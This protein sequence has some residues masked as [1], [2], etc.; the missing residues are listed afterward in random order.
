MGKTGM[1]RQVL[2]TI[3]IVAVGLYL[4]D[5]CAGSGR[6]GKSR[7]KDS[8]NDSDIQETIGGLITVGDLK[9]REGDML[10]I[11]STIRAPIPDDMDPTTEYRVT[12]D[13]YV[14]CDSE[15]S[16]GSAEISDEDYM[17]IYAFCVNAAKTGEFSKYSEDYLDGNTYKLTYYDPDGK[18]YVIYDGYCYDNDSLQ[19]IIILVEGYS[20]D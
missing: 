20:Y 19:D 5:G 17:E 9:R 18:E 10:V 13:G 8:D 1:I 15:Y 12:Y 11:E 3:L 2:G 16:N 7:D 4:L 6:E 14:Y